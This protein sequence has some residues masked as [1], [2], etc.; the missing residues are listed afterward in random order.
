MQF[1]SNDLDSLREKI[2]EQSDEIVIL[3]RLLAQKKEEMADNR[4]LLWLKEVLP[5]LW[6]PAKSLKGLLP[7][8]IRERQ[9]AEALSARK[10]FDADRYL[11][12]NP[13]VA[14]AGADALQ[15]YLTHGLWEGRPMGLEWNQASSGSQ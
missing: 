11:E 6:R 8:R 14:A 13:D 4:S 7:A 5:L 1:I 9:L 12:A 10:L 2:A 3:T 15:H